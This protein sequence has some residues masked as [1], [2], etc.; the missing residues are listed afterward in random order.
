MYSIVTFVQVTPGM[1]AEYDAFSERF[2]EHC[3]QV[4]GLLSVTQ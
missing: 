3:K 2:L 1:S 4:P